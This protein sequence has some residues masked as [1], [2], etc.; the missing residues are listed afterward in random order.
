MANKYEAHTRDGKVHHVTTP[1]HHDDHSDSSFKTILATA[2]A[3]GAAS[4]A[5]KTATEI[6]IT[7]FIFKGK[8]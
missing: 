2:I 4:G 3:S 6:I 7:R 1:H 5:A 8:H